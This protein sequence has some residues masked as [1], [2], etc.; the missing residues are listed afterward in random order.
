MPPLTGVGLF[1]IRKD[2]RLFVNFIA[3]VAVVFSV[4]VR[5]IYDDGSDEDLLVNPV[6][7]AGDRSQESADGLNRA[8]HDGWIVG[9]GLH[10]ATVVTKRGEFY[11]VISTTDGSAFTVLARGYVYPNHG[12]DVGSFTEPGP[13]GGEG[14]LRVVTGANPAAGANASDAVPTNALW[15]LIAYQIELVSVA[16]SS[17]APRLIAETPTRNRKWMGGLQDAVAGAETQTYLWGTGFASFTDAAPTPFSDTE[18]VSGRFEIPPN[19][20]LTE[21]D[22]IRTITAG[23]FQGT[24][25]YAAPAIMVEE[26][27]VI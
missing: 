20:F 9:G 5:V 7:S 26:W 21:A 13:G 25:N 17:A 3:S 23:T 16:G 18:A 27:L 2:D 14:V 10:S 24:D 1:R 15:R 19:L 11:A 4:R 8:R 22:V 12:L 6:T